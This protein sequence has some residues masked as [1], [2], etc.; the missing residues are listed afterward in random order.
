MGSGHQS[1]PHPP[2]YAGGLYVPIQ[3][4]SVSDGICLRAGPIPGLSPH[5][6]RDLCQSMNGWDVAR[7]ALSYPLRIRQEQVV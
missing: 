5:L 7:K 4:L 3:A 2:A 1:R 6:P